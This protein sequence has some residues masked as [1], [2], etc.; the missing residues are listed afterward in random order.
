MSRNL[1]LNPV[2][3]LPS[4]TFWKGTL[5]PG[6][7]PDEL[8]P[9]LAQYELKSQLGSIRCKQIVRWQHLSQIKARLLWL[10]EN[11]FSPIKT[12]QATSGTSAATNKLMEPHWSNRDHCSESP[13]RLTRTFAAHM[14]SQGYARARLR[15]RAPAT[16]KFSSRETSTKKKFLLSLFVSRNK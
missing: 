9:T 14:V 3:H 16:W 8:I 7:E 12:Q 5:K 13:A 11:V 4:A 6:S 15:E 10:V 1:S 2:L